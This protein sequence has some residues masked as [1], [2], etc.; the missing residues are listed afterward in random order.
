ML[1]LLKSLLQQELGIR[2]HLVTSRLHQ[3]KEHSALLKPFPLLIAALD[4]RDR[5]AECFA[6]CLCREA[7]LC[8]RLGFCFGCDLEL[9]GAGGGFFWYHLS[10]LKELQVVS[11]EGDAS[12]FLVGSLC[13]LR[14]VEWEVLE[15][16]STRAGHLG[17]VTQ[18]GI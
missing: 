10:Y 3:R 2:Q 7:P 9:R 6:T 11:G 15:G 18:E 13:W 16:I 17:Q 8:S 5:C 1:S 12:A 14:I 4:T